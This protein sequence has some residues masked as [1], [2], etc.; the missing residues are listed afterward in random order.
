MDLPPIPT[1][2][3]HSSCKTMIPQPQP[4]EKHLK[5]VENVVTVI[6]LLE[7]RRGSGRRKKFAMYKSHQYSMLGNLPRMK[8]GGEVTETESRWTT[9]RDH[10]M[11]V[12][13]MKTLRCREWVRLCPHPFLTYPPPCHSILI[14]GLL[15]F[16][17]LPIKFNSTLPS[18]IRPWLFDRNLIFLN[19][20][21]PPSSCHCGPH[22]L[23]CHFHARCS[24]PYRIFTTTYSCQ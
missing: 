2:Y 5:P 23:T 9:R 24:W 4:R 1:K 15:R 18:R 11:I 8:I 21:V 3:S 14:L 16:L 12:K 13:M 6:K 17:R 20:I 22:S 10:G 7:A 19:V